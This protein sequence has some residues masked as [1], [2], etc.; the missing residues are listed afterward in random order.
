MAPVA[1][2][3]AGGALTRGEAKK[4]GQRLAALPVLRLLPSIP[5]GQP[6]RTQ[7]AISPNDGRLPYISSPTR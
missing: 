4:D 1:L 7:R 2:R 5:A 6:A 3:E